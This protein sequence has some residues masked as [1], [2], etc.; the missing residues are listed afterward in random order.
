MHVRHCT[1]PDKQAICNEACICFCGR[2]LLIYRVIDDHPKLIV[3]QNVERETHYVDRRPDRIGTCHCGSEIRARCDGARSGDRDG[4]IFQDIDREFY[5]VDSALA[6]WLCGGHR[7]SSFIHC[8]TC[9]A[10]V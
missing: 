6:A 8:N 10:G 4:Y 5:F 3:I 2:K 7:V 1:E 9:A